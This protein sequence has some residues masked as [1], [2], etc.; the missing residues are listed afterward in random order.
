MKIRM[1]QQR[2]TLVS[3]YLFTS[4]F[5]L[6]F[7]SITLQAQSGKILNRKDGV[8]FK[9]A[10][11]AA[12]TDQLVTVSPG[13]NKV[14]VAG[15][16][17]VADVEGA[18]DKTIASF[19]VSN[20]NGDGSV[21]RITFTY[22]D[23]STQ[24]ATFNDN[25]EVSGAGSDGVVNGANFT[26][27]S[28]DLAITRSVGGDITVSLDGRYAL[29]IHTHQINDIVGL[30]GEINGKA[31]TAQGTRA[32]EAHSWGDHALE[33]YSTGAHT[34]DTNTQLS[35]AEVDAFTNNNGY[36]STEVD[37]TVA[38]HIK[39]ISPT[40]IAE[41]NEAYAKSEVSVAVTGDA[42]KTITLTR[43]DGS[44]ITG[45]FV[46]NNTQRANDGVINF[47]EFDPSDGILSVSSTLDNQFTASIDGRYSLLSHTHTASDITDF[48]TE[49]ANNTAVAANT[50]K[51]SNATHTGDVVGSTSLIIG[52]GRVTSAKIGNGAV[53][54]AKLSN[55]AANT[56]KGRSGMSGDPEDLTA[57]QVR[58][59]IGFDPSDYATSAQ[60]DLADNSVQKTGQTNQVI[61][62]TIQVDGSEIT[63]PIRANLSEVGG[64]TDYTNAY[65]SKNGISLNV[66]SGQSGYPSASGQLFRLKSFT[67]N[68]ASDRFTEFFCQAGNNEW[69]L[70]YISNGT[71]GG[72]K[73]IALSDEVASVAQGALADTALQP[74]G[75]GSQL[76]GV[77]ADLLRGLAPDDGVIASTIAQRTTAGDIQARLFRT[78]FPSSDVINVDA[79]V[80]MRN[81]NGTN[82]MGRPISKLG[83]KVWLYEATDTPWANFPAVSGL[84][85]NVRYK[86]K[87]GKLIMIGSIL[88]TSGSTISLLGTLPVGFRPDESRDVVISAQ[89]NGFRWVGIGSNGSI[90]GEVESGTQLEIDFEITLNTDD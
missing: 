18:V 28:G 27:T 38:A 80:I 64:A 85:S 79:Q 10:Q 54:N 37:P 35:E 60:G 29:T 15:T 7:A 33:G 21:K 49:V 8:Q 50:A 72:W 30:Q 1:R 11:P 17:T 47:I 87:N 89:A 46:D 66:I 86:R 78:N 32:D 41:W 84:A 56:I 36:L 12:A 65:L 75:D 43:Q 82:N 5:A 9:N 59:V 40:D 14:K 81:D 16:I 20:D 68:S 53:N 44:T 77:D 42:T 67:N 45:T 57:T 34:V 83:F 90:G 25:S 51:V 88:N 52:D 3:K 71:S 74:D 2:P 22:A 63:G 70:R 58:E 4:L 39:T 69:F 6:L 48:D 13:D 26:T 23:G 76:T 55:M 73:R 19:A 62:G 61:A 24:S 31:T